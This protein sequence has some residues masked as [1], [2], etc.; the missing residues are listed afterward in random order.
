MP[1]SPPNDDDRMR[2]EAGPRA[3]LIERYVAGPGLLA[4]AL[5]RLCGVDL[6][7]TFGET[8]GAGRWSIRGVF[9]HLADAEVMYTIRTRRM[10]AED[11]PTFRGWDEGAWLEH[12]CVRSARPEEAA[13]VVAA[14]RAWMVPL[15]GALE[16]SQWER[17]GLHERHGLHTL[18]GW[19]ARTTWHLERHCWFLERKIELLRPK[20]GAAG[21]AASG[22]ER[23]EA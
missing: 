17:V 6:D 14:L 20:A 9:C 10:L 12:L 21:A 18:A 5:G 8:Q 1:P 19:I 23:S 22:V 7:R 11:A 13:G 3:E 2:L 15:L 4:G 16:A